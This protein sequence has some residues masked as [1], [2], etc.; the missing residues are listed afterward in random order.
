MSGFAGPKDKV[1]A[2][3]ATYQWPV[4]LPIM[5]RA[6][7]PRPET[8]AAAPFAWMMARFSARVMQ[9]AH[10]WLPRSCE[11][12]RLLRY[13][14]MIDVVRCAHGEGAGCRTDARARKGE[15]IW[16]DVLAAFRDLRRMSHREVCRRIA[17]DPARF[18][19]LAEE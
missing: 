2:P 17:L 6:A 1:R 5:L 16:R 10:G 8:V 15:P 4:D 14:F 7:A 19:I 12:K 9:D 11:F 3:Q 13:Y 18:A